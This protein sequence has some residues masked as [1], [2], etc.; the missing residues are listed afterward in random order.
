MVYLLGWNIKGDSPH[1]HR[2]EMVHTRKYK[3]DA[4]TLNHIEED[5]RSQDFGYLCPAL[6]EPAQP[7]DD[8]SLILLHYLVR[9]HYLI[10]FSSLSGW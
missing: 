1:I 4:G 9:V 5:T 10:T 6:P 7:E 3:E 8:S 2:T